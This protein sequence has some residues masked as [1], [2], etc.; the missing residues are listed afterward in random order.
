MWNLTTTI[1]YENDEKEYSIDY[2]IAQDVAEG[3]LELMFK[4][5]QATSFVFTV[6]RRTPKAV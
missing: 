3:I 4:E 2:R 5:P 1:N 6:S